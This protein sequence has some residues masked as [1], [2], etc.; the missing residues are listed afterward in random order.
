MVDE[1]TSSRH[2][3]RVS[4]C[5]SSRICS[6]STSGRSA[7]LSTSAATV[8]LSDAQGRST[9]AGPARS[10]SIN[11]TSVGRK[12][13]QQTTK[14]SLTEANRLPAFRYPPRHCSDK[15]RGNLSWS[16]QAN[17]PPRYPQ[18]LSRD[19]QPPRRC[20]QSL[21]STSQTASETPSST[22][23]CGPAQAPRLHRVSTMPYPL[24][25]AARRSHFLSQRIAP[26]RP[27]QHH[28]S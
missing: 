2:R 9:T 23:P 10:T 3:E 26:A 12:I 4:R 1:S 19:H 28:G 22:N 8:A 17:E 7:P 25:L 14:R 6:S 21:V 11:A 5:G 20:R 16:N 27:L 24:A 18:G 15:G 13:P